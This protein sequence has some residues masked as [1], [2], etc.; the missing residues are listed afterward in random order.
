MLCGH[1]CA[2]A[3]YFKAVL[4]SYDLE[5]TSGGRP[6]TQIWLILAVAQWYTNTC[7]AKIYFIYI[8]L[9]TNKHT[10][11]CSLTR[12]GASFWKTCA[13]KAGRAGSHAHPNLLHP[14][15]LQV[16][17]EAWFAGQAAIVVR[18]GETA[19]LLAP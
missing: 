7:D 6:L 2:A 19:T 13:I 16:H 3:P 4:R 5:Q 11:K 8:H 9:K 12:A 15:P 10:N 17:E 14:N 18:A 1:I